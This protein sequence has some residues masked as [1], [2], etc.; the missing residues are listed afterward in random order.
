[1]KKILTVL[2]AVALALVGCQSSTSSENINIDEPSSSSVAS[3]SSEAVN[4]SK[5]LPTDYIVTE[6][7]GYDYSGSTLTIT[8]GVCKDKANNYDWSTVTQTGS[9]TKN[10]DGTV[11][12]DLGDGAGAHTFEFVG[13]GSFPNGDYYLSSTLDSALVLGFSLTSPKNYS[14]VIYPNTDCLFKY[15]GEMAETFIGIADADA[16]ANVVFGCKDLSLGGLKMTYISNDETSVDYTISFGGKSCKMHQ[17]FLYAYSEEDCKL[18]FENY[19][20]EYESGET[21]DFF[22]F[23]DYD[24]DIDGEEACIAVMEDYSHAA[25]LAKQAPVSMRQVKSVLKAIGSK[26]RNQ[27]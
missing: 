18:A 12:A 26:L 22:D 20:Q 9:L 10:D 1:M 16:S 19:R 7:G 21:K 24:Q 23:N 8:K 27:K 15:F 14:E 3:S 5:K 11:T 25:V 6:M 2:P 13:E 4:P 17:D